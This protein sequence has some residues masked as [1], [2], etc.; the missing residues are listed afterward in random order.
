MKH[1]FQLLVKDNLASCHGHMHCCMSKG[2]TGSKQRSALCKNQ[3]HR[4][5]VEVTVGYH[6]NTIHTVKWPTGRLQVQ[7]N[8]M[9]SNLLPHAT[10]DHTQCG[11]ASKPACF[12]GILPTASYTWQ[13]SLE[14]ATTSD[15]AAWCSQFHMLKLALASDTAR[16]VF[17][18]R[19]LFPSSTRC[20]FTKAFCKPLCK[21]A[22]VIPTT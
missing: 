22:C 13:R 7:Q 15:Q 6:G 18:G 11:E 10:A 16:L 1:D 20:S 12:K 17:H 21:A 14:P 3:G 19:S 8:T 4:S 9:S 5:S 2:C